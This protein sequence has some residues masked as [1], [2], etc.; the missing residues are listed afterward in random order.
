MIT[1]SIK[2]PSLFGRAVAKILGTPPVTY[3]SNPVAVMSPVPWTKI[4]YI[5][6]VEQIKVKFPIGSLVTLKQIP[7]IPDKVPLYYTV[8]YIEELMH[9][10]HYDY[11]FKEPQALTVRVP[12]GTFVTKCPCYLR[13]LTLEE[14]SLVNLSNQ[15]IQGTA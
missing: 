5:H 12:N 15:V 11:V 6:W 10:T 14:V 2:N 8:T 3:G 1:Y 4:A 9:E 13:V 7:V